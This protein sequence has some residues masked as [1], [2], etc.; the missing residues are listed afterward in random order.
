VLA[1]SAVDKQ[2]NEQGTEY[3]KKLRGV[4]PAAAGVAQAILANDFSAM[5]LG[6]LNG[7]FTDKDYEQ[8]TKVT[9]KTKD[10]INALLLDAQTAWKTTLSEFN[11]NTQDV[12]GRLGNNITKATAISFGTFLNTIEDKGADIQSFT[13]TLSSLI[14]SNDLSDSQQNQ[15]LSQ[16]GS[17]DFT[18]KEKG[19]NQLQIALE[20]FNIEV[21]TGSQAW[22]TLLNAFNS[23]TEGVAGFNLAN[24]RK[25]LAEISQLSSKIKVGEVISDEEFAKIRELNADLAKLFVMTAEG[26]TYLGGAG[27]IHD[28]LTKNTNSIAEKYN[29]SRNAYLGIKGREDQYGKIN[30]STLLEDGTTLAEL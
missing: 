9:G 6:G 1:Q 29:K 20:D 2:Q 18:D 30:Y 28:A 16:I 5:T 23:F 19:L 12:I 10:E 14:A 8:I 7:S 24:V 22:I 13:T 4:N 3:A 15:L 21:E 27:N 11:D 17:I 26:Y 25:E